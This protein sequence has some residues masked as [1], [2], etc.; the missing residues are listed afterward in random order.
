[1]K[2]LN[3]CQ[4]SQSQPFNISLMPPSDICQTLIF[5]H[6]IWN[7]QFFSR[8]LGNC[9]GKSFDALNCLLQ[10]MMDI[11]RSHWSGSRL[12]KS[13]LYLFKVKMKPTPK[14][15]RQRWCWPPKVGCRPDPPDPRNVILPKAGAQ[16]DGI[17]SRRKIGFF[18]RFWRSV[19]WSRALPPSLKCAANARRRKSASASMP[20]NGVRGCAGHT[21][22]LPNVTGFIANIHRSERNEVSI[23]S[24]AGQKIWCLIWSQF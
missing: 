21:S 1:M 3:C 8:D 17:K 11:C 10:Y 15:I 16:S 12:S 18:L 23:S 14:E 2:L 22:C 9:V 24:C 4:I 5:L 13:R 20:S 19:K 7:L 6:Q